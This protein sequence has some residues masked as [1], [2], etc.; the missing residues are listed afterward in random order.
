MSPKGKLVSLKAARSRNG[1]ITV[2]GHAP[3]G[4][5]QVVGF[6]AKSPAC[7]RASWQMPGP[8]PYRQATTRVANTKVAVDYAA[9]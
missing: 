3:A 1:S 2:S 7:Y 8:A 5:I 9:V 4:D 6:Q